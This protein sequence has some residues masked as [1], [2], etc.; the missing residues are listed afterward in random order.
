[1]EKVKAIII[2]NP[3]DPI[4]SRE[5]RD[6]SPGVTVGRAMQDF[7]PLATVEY[8]WT[9]AVNGSIVD[10]DYRDIKLVAGDCLTFCAT[11]Q[12]DGDGK[13]P[14]ALVA[15]MAVMVVATV[16]SGGAAGA[17]AAAWGSAAG[18]VA[19]AVVY[20]GVM[21]AGGLLVNSIFPAKVPSMDGISGQSF[22]RSQTYGWRTGENAYE[23]GTPL[24]VLYGT[25]RVVPPR[26]AQYVETKGNE[27][28]LNILYAVAGHELDSIDDIE[29][30]DQPIEN[31][32]DVEVVKRF[33]ANNQA[34]IGFFSDQRTDT[35]IDTA[36]TTDWQTKQI[37][38]NTDRFGVGLLAPVGLYYANDK[39]GL[40]QVTLYINMEYRKIGSASW[41]PWITNQAIK[42][43]QNSPKRWFFEMDN[44]DYVSSEY[45]YRFKFN[46]PPPSGSRYGSELKLEYHQAILEEPAS[47]PNTALI[48]LRAL[49]TDQ[50]SGSI[51]RMSCLVS[52]NTI[53]ID[54]TPKPATNPA[55]VCAHMLID[56]LNGGGEPIDDVTINM[57]DEWADD[58]DEYDLSC[59]FYFDSAMNLKRAM[60]LVG[61][62]GWGQVIQQ[63]T[64]YT[65]LTDFPKAPA[66]KFTFGM[67]NIEADSFQE[68]WLPTDE[69]ADEIE[70]TYWDAADKHKRKM[71][72]VPQPLLSPTAPTINKQSLT[73]YG[74]DN[75]EQAVH[76]AEML[77]RKNFYLTLTSSWGADVDALAC[78]IGDVVDLSHD[79]PMFGY[80][81]RVVAAA[82]NSVQLDREVTL[83]PG[84]TYVVDVRLSDNDARVTNTAT[85][86]VETTTNTITL[87]SNWTAIPAKY[88]NYSFGEL[89]QQYRQFRILKISKD[90]ELRRKV[91]AIEYVPEVWDRT[92]PVPIPVVPV[93][94]IITGLQL[95]EA[96]ASSSDGSGYPVVYAS[97]RSS[98]TTVTVHIRLNEEDEPWYFIKNSHNSRAV[99]DVPLVVGLEYEVSIALPASPPQSGEISIIEIRGKEAA[100]GPVSSITAVALSTGIKITWSKTEEIDFK[101]YIIA[102]G[103]S[104]DSGEE[105]GRSLTSEFWWTDTIAPGTYQFWV[106]VENRSG[107]ITPIEEIESASITITAPDTPVISQEINKESIV[108]RWQPCSTSFSVSHYTVND[109]L[110]TDEFAGR[111]YFR[112][113]D[114]TGDKDFQIKA[115]DVFGNESAVATETVT[116]L[117]IPAPTAL[118]TSGHPYEIRLTFAYTR[119]AEFDAL[120]I[121]QSGTNNRNDAEKVA[122]TGQNSHTISGVPLIT[123]YYFWIRVRNQFGDYS[124]WYPAGVNEGIIGAAGND[125][126]DY[127]DVLQGDDFSFVDDVFEDDMFGDLWSQYSSNY[128]SDQGLYKKIVNLKRETLEGFAIAEQEW[129]AYADSDSAVAAWRSSLEAEHGTGL[130][131]I[132][133]NATAISTLD[134]EVKAE[135]GL[136]LNANGHITGFRSMV[137]HTGQ[138]EFD[139]VTDRFR[140][141][142]QDDA[143]DMVVPFVIGKINGN[144]G[145]GINGDLFVDGSISGSAINANSVITIGVLDGVSDYIVL[146]A[147]SGSLKTYKYI[148]GD[149][150]QYK[151][152]TR[153]ESGVAS[154]GDKV[155][156]AGYFESEPE[157]LVSINSLAAYDP[158]YSNQKQSWLCNAEN[159]NEFSDGRWEFDVSAKLVLDESSG[160]EAVN[161]DTTTTT[162]TWESAAQISPD[163]TEE[164]NVKVRFSSVRGT[165]TSSEYYKRKVGW[166]IGFSSDGNSYTWTSWQTK[167]IGETLNAVND[168]R[169]LTLPSSGVWYIKV[170]YEADDAGGIFTTGSTKYDYDS[171]SR[172]NSGPV[173]EEL[174]IDYNCGGCDSYIEANVTGWKFSYNLRE[175]SPGTYSQGSSSLSNWTTKTGSA[176]SYNRNI[177]SGTLFTEVK[178]PEFDPQC[179]VTDSLLLQLDAY[180]P[181]AGWSIYNVQYSYQYAYY[182][183]I[184]PDGTAGLAE[185]AAEAKLKFRNASAT[186]Y[187]RKPK[188]NTTTPNNMFRFTS[189]DFELSE[190]EIVAT[191]SINWIAIGE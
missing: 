10:G 134:G 65:C 189:Y 2:R 137:D 20:G 70:V 114:W 15:M 7:F 26:I 28:Y 125:P 1:M 41:Q 185:C 58:C 75:I 171:V 106:G 43:K 84:T 24:P 76:H 128:E 56:T 150:R 62:L 33:G 175:W 91:T 176:S 138:S 102:Q 103:N 174:F 110:N 178:K 142:N 97:W 123:N 132:T 153:R 149:Y 8:D 145:V 173:E 158:A 23:P 180:S 182:L 147:P 136:W 131:S 151:Q 117:A 25:H 166:R 109:G 46:T 29:L 93:G 177:F 95:T 139:I 90:Q 165:G 87:D 101:E 172:S 141:I 89:N 179:S 152:L 111:L 82:V 13:N 53:N 71:V 113:I 74:C 44:P 86:D 187:I 16:V 135:Y 112:R 130:A 55:W 120:E 67:G 92:V 121:W 155:Q 119:T 167:D 69:R 191:G 27:Q 94:D 104:F 39:G 59:N 186:I 48:G 54:G 64:R 66:Q 12:S 11:P 35:A 183:F 161:D 63:G 68:E 116:I 124:D 188:A 21:V 169:L 19:G 5:T 37:S 6:F 42:G 168:S 78:T 143:G 164:V 129:Q 9:V 156:I 51:P 162:N 30:N 122:E 126:S 115:I 163:N 184:K 148:A 146:D 60:D 96:W 57:F 18:K 14:F 61:T 170:Q 17:A 85:V 36:F 73:L 133:E 105:I 107:N 40:S 31:F 108:L 100:P 72:T 99:I 38:G 34:E 80:S 190:A 154:S 144:P 32:E 22:E 49:A 77:L 3:F 83:S 140:V 160:E 50:L 81:G 157:I 118:T 47:Y 88:D 4:A 45:E 98:V 79:V 52:R 181:P 159:I 127:L